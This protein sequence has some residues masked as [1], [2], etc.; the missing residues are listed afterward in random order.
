MDSL[1]DQVNF[2]FRDLRSEGPIQEQW[3]MLLRIEA[4]FSLTVRGI[5]VLEDPHFN[6][7]E[8]ASAASKWLRKPS[9]DFSFRTMDAEERDIV[10]FRCEGLRRCVGSA[11]GVADGVPVDFHELSEGLQRFIAKLA[12]A[13]QRELHVDIRPI[14]DY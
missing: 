11:W 5:T 12:Y 8:F 14:L 6:V 2:A 7:V 3:Q 1:S 9:S 13:C 4:A 10:F